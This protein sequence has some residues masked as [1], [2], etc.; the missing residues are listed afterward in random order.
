MVAELLLGQ[1]DHST[2]AGSEHPWGMDGWVRWLEGLR[3]GYERRMQAMCQI[4]DDGKY[5]ITDNTNAN[6][7]TNTHHPDTD[8]DA[9]ID[10]WEVL[11]KTQLYDFTYPT[12]G[13]FVWIKINF[14]SHRLR[15]QYQVTKL[16]K[17]L[18]THLTRKPYL[19]LVGPGGMFASTGKAAQAAPSYMRLCFAAMD[20]REVVD[21]SRRVVEGFRAFWERKDLDGLDGDDEDEDEDE[22]FT[23]AASGNGCRPGLLGFGC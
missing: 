11:T 6:T 5:I 1:P 12:G 14:D 23:T 2:R 7:N 21:V 9:E 19:C 4:L 8:S 20:E 18:W 22:E 3:S 16:S 13:M 15:H 17:A 10:T